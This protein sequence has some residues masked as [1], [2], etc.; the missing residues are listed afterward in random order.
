MSEAPSTMR[1]QGCLRPSVLLAR[2]LLW[3][4][5]KLLFDAS[6][7]DPSA[8]G[9]PRMELP[10]RLSRIARR[11]LIHTGHQYSQNLLMTPVTSEAKSQASKTRIGQTLHPGEGTAGFDFLSFHVRQYP[12]GQTKTGKTGRGQPLGFTT[13]ITPSKTGQRRH[14]RQMHEEVRRLR[15]SSQEVLIKRLNPI[16]QGGS[17]YYATVASKKTF[18]RMDTAL[19]AN[20]RRWACRRHPDKSAWWISEQYWHPRQGQWTFKTPAGIKLERHSATPIRRYTKVTGTRSPYD[21]AW[22]YWASRLGRHPE[23]PRKWAIL[24]KRQGGRC[25]WCGLY[26]K[27]E[28]DLVERDHIIPKSHGGD[29]KTAN[30]QLLHGHCHDVKTA[31][32]KAVAGTPDRSHIAEEPCASKDTG[33]VLKPR[34]RG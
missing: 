20:L 27:H 18:V 6:N 12:G 32:D 2:A 17:N 5:K 11:C 31:K 4:R 28:E 9:R 26:F 33:T 19:Y 30:L 7:D 10:E 3:L 16:I 22:S 23:T 21:G 14:L 25:S 1:W 34:Q 29:G 13:R 15:A 24:L 8:Y